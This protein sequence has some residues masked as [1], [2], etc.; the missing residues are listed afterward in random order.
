MI[1]NN[2]IYSLNV[3][4]TIKQLQFN[5]NTEDLSVIVFTILY[6]NLYTKLLV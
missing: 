5:I 6:T 3:L 4:S 1:I 2:I